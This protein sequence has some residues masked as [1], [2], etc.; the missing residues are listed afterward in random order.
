MRTVCPSCQAAYDVPTSVLDA[1]RTLRCA[2]CATDFRPNPP[3]AERVPPAALAVV[4][5]KLAPVMP[6]GRPRPRAAVMAGWVV[7][8]MVLVAMGW[9]FMAWR[10]PIARVWPASERVYAALGFR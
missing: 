4:S 1:G 3:P 9:S 7:S 2:R 6:D 5:D 8:F 10:V